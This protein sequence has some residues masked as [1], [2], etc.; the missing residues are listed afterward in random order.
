MPYT[1][2]AAVKKVLLDDYDSEGAP[3]LTPFIEAAGAMLS[4]VQ[5][6]AL[7]KGITLSDTL[8]E[9]IE[10]WLSAH[11]Y[12]VS[13]SKLASARTGEAAG[14]FQ[15]KTGMYLESTTYGQAAMSLDPSGCLR[16]IDVKLSQGRKV[17]SVNWLGLRRSVRKSYAERDV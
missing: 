5:T 16:A 2:A 11:F 1:T 12:C 6:C 15:G 9:I 17:A 14:A 8:N 10:R 13:D 7:A 3:D 4:A